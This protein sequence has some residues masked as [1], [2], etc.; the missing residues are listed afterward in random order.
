[1]HA[2]ER[3]PKICIDC[4]RGFNGTASSKRCRSCNGLAT[5]R[6]KAERARK[7]KPSLIPKSLPRPETNRER[8]ALERIAERQAREID[9]EDKPGKPYRA[10]SLAAAEAITGARNVA[11][12]REHCLTGK[13]GQTCNAHSQGLRVE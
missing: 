11:V 2:N 8:L 12:N 6:A 13:A 7:Y 9:V 5:K 1:M 10:P 3:R 4:D